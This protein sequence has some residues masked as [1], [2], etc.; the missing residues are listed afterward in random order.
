MKIGEIEEL[1]KRRGA[2][3]QGHFLLSSGKH[4]SGYMQCA[5]VLQHP[6]DAA[7]LGEML[8]DA[9]L[10]AGFRPKVVVSPAMGGLIIGHET[11]R[12]LG[13]RFQFME[14]QSGTFTLR[15]GF[16]LSPGEETA[17]IEDV[18]TT[19]LSTRECIEVA[20]V[21]GGKVICAGSVV[22]RSDGQANVG[23]PSFSL[24]PLALPLWE[25]DECPLCRQGLPCI[26]PG[27]RI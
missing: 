18:I 2:Y 14:R 27:S 24:W 17:V 11:A 6:D 13:I 8:A 22:D 4:S 5:L 20:E 10:Q 1:F 25:P 9:I 26:K 16:Q 21:H 7:R 12:A 15:R 3:L 19:G 23:C